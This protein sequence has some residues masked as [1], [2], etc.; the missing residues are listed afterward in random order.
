MGLDFILD[1]VQRLCGSPMGELLLQEIVSHL[2]MSVVWTVRWHCHACREPRSGLRGLGA[3]S[4]LLG[5]YH[6]TGPMLEGGP[7]VAPGASGLACED[8]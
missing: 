7:A 8:T 4:G 5:T 1:M 3:E 6:S 2:H